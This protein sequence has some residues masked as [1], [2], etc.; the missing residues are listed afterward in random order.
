MEKIKGI[1]KVM[2]GFG[3]EIL[4]YLYGMWPLNKKNIKVMNMDETI[5]IMLNTDKSLVRFGDG[6][7]ELIRGKNISFQSTDARLAEELKNILF[8]DNDNFVVALPDIF[9]GVDQY[10]MPSQHFW[11]EHLLF[12]RRIYIQNC[13][14][15]KV[16]AS[17]FFSRCYFSI[18]DKKQCSRWFEKIKSIWKDCEIV[19]IEGCRAHS[20]VENDL[21]DQAKMVERIICPS[22]NAY[23]FYSAILEKCRVFPRTKLMLVSLGPT[24]KVLAAD[25]FGSG[26]RVIDIGNLDI[27][28]EWY[29]H[30]ELTKARY[31]KNDMVTVQENLTAGYTKYLDEI[32]YRIS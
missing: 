3:S 5:D 21:F 11:K 15:N 24:A 18:A 29:I 9:D 28:Y 8:F 31:S 7:M 26:Y 17:A 1:K 6:E 32:K 4:Y 19:I 27:E 13:N 12:C 10:I 30:G 25:L 22:D 23:Q 2:K 14:R 16:Y 20:G